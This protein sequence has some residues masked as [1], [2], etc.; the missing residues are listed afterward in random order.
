[1]KKI[2]LGFMLLM[3]SLTFTQDG[4]TGYWM[5][6]EGKFIIHIQKAENNEYVGHVAWLKDLY[7]PVGDKMEGIE[8]Y[9]RNNPDKTLRIESRKVMGLPVVGELFEKNGKLQDG[10]IYDSWNG[11]LYHGSAKLLDENTLKLRGSF[12]K[13]GILG[14][15][16]KAKRVVNLEKYGI[17]TDEK[18]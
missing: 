3:T 16:Q 15:S 6:P 7:Y 14:L 13:W 4:Y 10:W 12:D 8:Q 1:M 5:M 2:I 17:Q 18:K 9:D 11:K